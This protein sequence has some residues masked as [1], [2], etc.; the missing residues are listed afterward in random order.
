MIVFGI[1]YEN[2]EYGYRFDGPWEP[3]VGHRFDKSKI[4]MD[5][6]A[7]VIGGR[8]VWGVKPNWDDAY[9]HRSRLVFDDFDWG[10][11]R[12]L[13]VPMEDLVIYEAH[14]RSFTADPSSGR[15]VSRHFC[16]HPR[17]DSLSQRVGHQLYRTAAHLR[18]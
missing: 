18:V 11:D 6:Y 4:L 10:D 5:P 1:D 9:Q 7:R 2:T 3:E 16:R 8:D 14:V 15:Q 17:E 12:P 13:E